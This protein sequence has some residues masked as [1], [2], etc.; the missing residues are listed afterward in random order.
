LLDWPVACFAAG[1][2]RQPVDG[3]LTPQAFD[4]LVTAFSK[5]VA[6]RAMNGELDHHLGCAA[7]ADKSSG[8]LNE[9][10]GTTSKTVLTKLARSPSKCHAIGMVVSSFC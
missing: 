8:Q 10:N 6:E 2:G 1:L 4:D 9:R 5:A 7:G 3:P